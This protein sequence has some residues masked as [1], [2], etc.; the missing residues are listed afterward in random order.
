MT[1]FQLA[2]DVQ[3]QLARVIQGQEAV[4]R[5]MVACLLARGHVLLEGVP[6]LAKTLLAK[7]LAKAVG[8][9]CRRVQFTPDL[10]PSDLSG[11]NVFNLHTGQFQLH[12]GPVFTNLLLADEI[13]RTSPK[14]QAALLQA[15]EERQVNIDGTDHRLPEPFFVMATQNPIEHEGTY[16]LPQAQ[17]D[18]FLMKVLVDYP[19]EEQEV[20]I[21]RLH[22]A[23]LDPHQLTER[24]LAPVAS[25]E[26]VEACAVAIRQVTVEDGMLR[27]VAALARETRRLPRVLLGA[28]PRAGAALLTCAKAMAAITD[29]EFLVPDDV[30]AVAKPVLRHRL[31]LQPEAELEGLTPDRIIEA[32]LGQ[33]P[34]PR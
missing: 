1:P 30:K 22:H 5:Q 25:V 8:A 29:R 21:L 32:V 24:D 28:S 33:V 13:N 6:G 2:N 20:G 27:Y 18:R 3:A 11:V 23:G 16:P 19:D 34:V 7:A 17:L 12:L 9:E 31:I 26:Q 10:M 14:T 15:M 4:I